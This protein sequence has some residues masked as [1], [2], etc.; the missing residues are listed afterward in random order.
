MMKRIQRLAI[1]NGIACILHLIVVFLTRNNILNSTGIAE[2]A[3]KYSTLFTPTRMTYHIWELIYAT[4]FAFCAYHL[5]MAYKQDERHPANAVVLKI[6]WLF[7]FVNIAAA[8]R[9]LA[10]TQEWLSL[11][12]IMITTQLFL[13]LKIHSRLGL[14]DSRR[15]LES[16]VFTQFTIS[17]YLGWTLVTL[18]ANIGSWL[19]AIQW[20][21]WGIS[22]INW[23]ITQIAILTLIAMSI[24]SSKN[25]VV[26][27][28]AVIWGFYGIT[29]QRIAIDQEE[30]QPVI[31]VARAG[32][33]IVAF[34][35][36]T[37]FIRNLIKRRRARIRRSPSSGPDKTKEING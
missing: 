33:A 8:I 12:L 17:L 22:S 25:N 3:Q 37:A 27:G 13:L 4:L 36:L 1:Y 15:S 5:V 6:G 2:I 26:F 18:F 35:C 28:L 10:W 9:L 11:C 20:N 31:L 14:Y 7:V 16:K 29:L 24:V 30:Y 19:V 32:M 21:G 23:T 34:M